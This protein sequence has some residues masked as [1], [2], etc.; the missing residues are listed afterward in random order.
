MSQPPRGSYS[1][2]SSGAVSGE[3]ERPATE[4]TRIAPELLFRVHEYYGVHELA[5]ESHVELANVPYAIARPSNMMAPQ[6]LDFIHVAD[7]VEALRRLS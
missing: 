4:R 3:T 1:S 2:S 6:T 7:V 5:A